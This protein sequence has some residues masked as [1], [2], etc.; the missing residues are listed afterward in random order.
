[1]VIPDVV[2]DVAGA[3]E[4]E[5]DVAL[6]SVVPSSSGTEEHSEYGGS[7]PRPDFGPHS[8]EEFVAEPGEPDDVGGGQVLTVESVE[9]GAAGGASADNA[10]TGEPAQG[11]VDTP[12]ARAIEQSMNVAAGEVGVCECKDPENVSINRWGDDREGSRQLH[13]SSKF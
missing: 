2:R 10:L 11:V 9:A 7:R 6:S 1:M 3:D 5:V 8:L 12:D 13:A 4:E